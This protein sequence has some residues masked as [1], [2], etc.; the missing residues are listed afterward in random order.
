MEK[1]LEGLGLSKKE[2]T[3]YLSLLELGPSLVTNIAIRAKINRTTCY[4]ILEKLIEIGLISKVTATGKKT[5]TA[6]HPETLIAYLERRSNDFKDRAKEIGEYLPELRA[7]YNEKGKQ[8]LVKFY[9]GI[10]GIET[11]YEDTLTSHET[12]RAY[13]SVRDMHKA[14]PNYFPD[15]YHR[16]AKK[17]IFINAILPATKEAIER[18]L[19]DKAEARKSRLV[20]IDKFNFSPEIN[21]YDNKVAIMSLAEEFGVIIES[22]EIAEAQKKIFSLAWETAKQF[23]KKIR[24]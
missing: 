20:P 16:R 11:V 19:F 4:D 10:Q 15:Y 3:V 7:I 12:I 23:D 14:L 8:P 21:I 2:S 17:K 5:Y 22:K 18:K 13:A 1:I 24:K 9:E 6:E